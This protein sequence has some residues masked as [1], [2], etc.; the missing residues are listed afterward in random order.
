MRKMVFTV[1]VLTATFLVACSEGGQRRDN[2]AHKKKRSEIESLSHQ[3]LLLLTQQWFLF[4]FGM[5]AFIF[6]EI[7][8]YHQNNHFN[9]FQTLAYNCANTSF[10]IKSTITYHAVFPFIVSP[11][12]QLVLLMPICYFSVAKWQ[13][14]CFHQGGNGPGVWEC[15]PYPVV[16]LRC[17]S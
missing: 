2:E 4:L 8:F 5:N 16:P 1:E 9:E 13:E 7:Y 11:E 14:T 15:S 3:S 17:K 6:P 10:Q 12:K